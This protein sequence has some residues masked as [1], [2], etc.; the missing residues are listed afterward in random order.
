MFFLNETSEVDIMYADGDYGESPEKFANI[1]SLGLAIIGN[2]TEEIE[3]LLS[4]IC[5]PNDNKTLHIPRCNLFDCGWDG[6]PFTA[7]LSNLHIAAMKG[8]IFA[9]E[10]LL[11]MENIA[12]DSRDEYEETPLMYAVR[13]PS[14]LNMLNLLVAAGADLDAVNDDGETPLYLAITF[15]QTEV[16]EFLIN[17]GAVPGEMYLEYY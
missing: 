8:N 4:G 1:S 3:D 16:V 7:G 6:Y 10:K 15:G 14:K 17:K 11:S 5:D 9:L 12:V 13:A 2:K